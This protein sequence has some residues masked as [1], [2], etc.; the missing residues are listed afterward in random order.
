[1]CE[2]CLQIRVNLSW[3]STTF[4][5]QALNT[6]P[7]P[8]KVLKTR[9]LFLAGTQHIFQHLDTL[10]QLFQFLAHVRQSTDVSI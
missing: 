8:F 3:L 7:S 9:N 6:A 5:R 4:F 2:A 1:V 10:S